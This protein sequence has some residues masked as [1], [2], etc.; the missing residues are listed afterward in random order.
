MRGHLMNV[1]DQQRNP[2]AWIE[3]LIRDF[4][5]TSPINTLQNEQNDK[6]WGDPLVGFSRGDDP[7]YQFYKEHVGPFHLT[8]VEIFTQTFPSAKVTPDQLTII[9]WV[10]PHM[11]ETKADNRKETM[12]PSERWARA[13]IFGEKIN[14]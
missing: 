4:I 5:N 7:L 12:Y 2:A 9:S 1:D 10:L 14:R 8:P 13:R 6:A 3:K 11:E